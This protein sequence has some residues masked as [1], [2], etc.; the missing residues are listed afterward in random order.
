MTRILDRYVIREFLRLFLLFSIAAPILFVIGDLTDN[1]DTYLERGYSA[2]QIIL[3][4]IYQ[5]PLFIMYSFPIAALIGTI[6]TVNN[7][8]RHSELTAAKAGGISFWRLLA[9]LPVLGIVL[10]FGALGLS[11]LVPITSRLRTE[12]LGEQTRNR[13]IRSDFVYRAGNGFVY[14]VRR[15]DVAQSQMASV[16]V[17]REGNEPER[18]SLHIK[19]TSGTWNEE[20]GWTLNNGQMRL[21]FGPDA[22]RQFTFDQL[23]LLEFEETPEELLAEPREPEEMGYRE[24][25]RFIEI[26]QR[27]G[28]EP[29]ELMVEQAQKIALPVATLL[30]ILFGAPLANSTQRGGAAYGI[31]ISLGITVTYLMMFKVFGAMGSAGA[32]PPAIAAWL[33][34]LILLAASGFLL[35]RV[36]T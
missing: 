17:E 15:L 28:G 27:S 10:T 6:F 35:V 31:G 36:K 26:I 7:M 11:E 4:E 34:N 32:I 29:L 12:L 5:M 9:P 13:T 23:R 30:I 2:T 16:V 22:E 25:D 8:T 19:A 21:F 24:L 3:N 20:S 1:I 14:Q 33:P 18:P